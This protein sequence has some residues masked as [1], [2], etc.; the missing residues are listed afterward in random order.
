MCVE[1]TTSAV[2]GRGAT[3]LTKV[4]LRSREDRFFDAAD[5]TGIELCEGEALGAEVFE[6]CADEV[7]FLVV[8]DEE[9]VVEGFVVADGEF[10]VLGVEGRDVG[11]GNLAVGHMLPVVMLRREDR[12]PRA[13][14][15]FRKEVE[16][17]RIHPVVN[18]DQ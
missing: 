16:H 14:P 5:F 12:Q 7:E 11:G 2:G 3:A 8:D 4:V 1:A 9:T 10:R 17:L 18:E 13:F 6:R 15:L